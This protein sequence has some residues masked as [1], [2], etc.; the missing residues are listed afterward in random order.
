MSATRPDTPPGLDVPYVSTAESLDDPLPDRARDEPVLSARSDYRAHID[1]VRALAVVLVILFHLGYS[2]IPG[3]FIGVDVFFV[4]SGYLIT[5]LLLREVTEHGRIRMQNFYARRIRRLLAASA[6]VILVVIGLSAWLL[7]AVDKRLV[8]NDATAAA[9]YIANWHFIA[10]GRDYFVAG[11]VPSPLIH[12]WSLAVEEQFYVVWPALFLF[13]WRLST[14]RRGKRRDRNA[15]GWLLVAIGALLGI[16]A[17]LSVTLVPSTSA[18]YGAHTRAYQLLAGAVLA[19][20]AVRW[21]SKVPDT[22]SVRVSAGVLAAA[23]LAALVYLATAIPD[24]TNY[25]GGA[26]L[27]VTAASFV[28]LAALDLTPRGLAHKIIGSTVP[29]AV[30]RMSY[31]LYLWHW[32]VIVF[33]PVIAK[34]FN[35]VAPTWKW[36]Q[37]LAMAVAAGASYLLIERPVRFKLVKRAPALAVVAV[38]LTISG[39]VA[40][41]QTPFLQPHNQYQ[42]D[43]LSAAGDV[44]HSGKCPYTSQAWGPPS[45]AEPCLY[46]KGGKF[47]VALV[48]DSH[49]QQWQ[50]AWDVIGKKYNLTIV[51]ATYKGCPA[52][53]ILVNYFDNQGIS[54]AGNGCFQ[55][56]AHVYP[57]IVSRFHPDLIYIETRSQDWSIR[58]GP[59]N[60]FVKKGDK[61][62]VGLW[63][64]GWTKTLKTLTAGGTPVVVGITTPQMPFRVP[65][66]LI[67]KGQGT[68]ACDVPLVETSEVAPYNDVIRGLPRR[69]RGVH[70][71]DTTPIICPG[72][73]CPAIMNNIV[74]HRDDDH[75][76]ATFARSV[77]D[78]YQALI[79]ATGVT[80]PKK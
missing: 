23:A 24:A 5:G 55:W 26:A 74:V 78:Q 80:F 7:D 52:N 35:L 13:I 48:G 21:R 18:Y 53:W 15:T 76:S 43:V 59:G 63:S 42:V 58:P 8:G 28:L 6:V 22:R 31:S 45:K 65:A 29:A 69:A 57:R 39:G 30:G 46:R 73:V 79:A 77:A 51:R 34:K 1:G 38:G 3:G 9:A 68:K 60:S 44:A 71:I 20:L 27:A 37:V 14:R 17:V 41:A 61:R 2:W 75:L 16:S 10:D 36:T 50:P 32:P 47:V 62:H 4:L 66:C 11:D 19:V 49:A 56:R 25:P 12:F 70:V 33:A 54:H 72:K 40:F 64:A 67:A